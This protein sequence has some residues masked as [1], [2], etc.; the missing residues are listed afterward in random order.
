MNARIIILLP[1]ISIVVACDGFFDVTNPGPLASDQL[2]TPAAVP[3]LV[4]GMSGDL[5]YALSRVVFTSGLASGELGHGGSYFWAGRM[6][7]GLLEGEDEGPDIWGFMHRARWVAES[8]IERIEGLLGPEAQSDALLARANLLAGFA[9]RLLGENVCYAVIDGGEPQEHTVHFNRAQASF[10][11]AIE[12]A[13]AAG[14]GA[15]E[16]AALGGRASVRA[17]L[18]DWAGA[19]EDA[20]LVPDDF[21]YEAIFSLNSGRE[22]NYMYAETHNRLEASVYNTEWA[23]V[24]GDPRVQWDTLYDAGGAVRLGQ[25]GLTPH[26]QQMKYPIQSENIVLTR[27]AEMLLIRAEERLRDE[28]PDGAMGFINAARVQYG[29]A[30][31]QSA[32]SEAEAWEILQ[33]ERGSVLWLEARRLWDM[34]RWNAEGLNDF[35]AARDECF[36]ISFDEL[37]AG[38]D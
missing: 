11:R 37:M 22:N 4:A 31:D 7:R 28:D 8:G 26:F 9:N 27:G 2:N 5:S 25:D 1:L 6:S 36:P 30:P 12:V 18:G 19:V 35:L 14:A 15:I 33:R 3:A 10:T 32:A 20:A 29:L 24:H 38:S 13:S 34:R 16:S 23:E 17:A 21:A